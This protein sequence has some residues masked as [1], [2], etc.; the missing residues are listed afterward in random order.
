MREREPERL[1]DIE[2]LAPEAIS[3]SLLDTGTP[4]TP[5]VPAA[6]LLRFVGRGSDAGNFQHAWKG[7]PRTG[8]V[9]SLLAVFLFAFV[10]IACASAA[11]GTIGAVLGQRT[12]GRLFVRGVPAGEGADRA[13]LEIEDE[14]VAIDGR[15]VKEMSQEDVRKAVRGD[16]GSTLLLTVERNGQRRDVKVQRSPILADKPAPRPSSTAP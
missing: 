1:K 16:V 10:M 11:P 13:G 12:D 15:P 8:S 14:I 3:E 4:G 9:V 6:A 2:P 5:L 7:R